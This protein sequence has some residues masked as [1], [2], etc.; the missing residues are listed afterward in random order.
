MTMAVILLLELEVLPLSALIAMAAIFSH[1]YLRMTV[2]STLYVLMMSPPNLRLMT[3]LIHS[4]LSLGQSTHSLYII[5]TAAGAQGLRRWSINGPPQPHAHSNTITTAISTPT[6]APPPTATI[7][8]I[9]RRHPPRHA[10][11]ALV[12]VRE[13]RHRTVQRLR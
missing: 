12:R 3:T 13:G 6:A 1:F 2:M 11:H 5:A 7:S 8:T 9:I 4:I 10:T